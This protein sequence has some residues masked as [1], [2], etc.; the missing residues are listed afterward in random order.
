MHNDLPTVDPLGIRD[1]VLSG[2]VQS[3]I[4]IRPLSEWIL[5]YVVPFPANACAGAEAGTGAVLAVVRVTRSMLLN[6][7]G[8]SK[9]RTR[10]RAVQA[11]ARKLDDRRLFGTVCRENSKI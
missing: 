5:A 10:S 11:S 1:K 3:S 8:C 9:K 6:L 2:S 4:R 7:P